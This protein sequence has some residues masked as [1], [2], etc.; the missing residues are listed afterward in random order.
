MIWLLL[1][2]ADEPVYDTGC[3][4]QRTWDGWAQ[5]WFLTWCQSCHGSQAPD[6]RGAPEAVI[7]DTEA[8][9]W[10][11]EDRV[12]ATVFELESMPLGGGLPGEEAAALEAWLDCPGYSERTEE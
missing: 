4:S 1:A 2:C 6:R 9:V 12:R 3:D 10:A 5:G 11:V 8:D 7:F